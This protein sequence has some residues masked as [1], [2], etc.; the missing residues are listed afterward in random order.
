MKF[1][2][3]IG[4]IRIKEQ[5]SEALEKNRLSH[6]LLFSG[7]SG[8]GKRQMAWALA[9]NLLC[10]SEN[11]ACGT[12][13][14]CHQI[15][16]RMSESVFVVKFETLQIRI[17]DVKGIEKFISLQT[18]HKAKIVLID[19]A[20][21]LNIRSSNFLLKL[22]EEPP[23]KTYFFLISSQA[24]KLPLT[25]RSRMQNLHFEPLRE[26]ELRHLIPENYEEWMIPASRGQLDL[27]EMFSH[28]GEER[29][30]VILLLEEF[31][32]EKSLSL[33]SMDS[34]SKALT[35]SVFNQQILRDARLLK[36]GMRDKIIHK[37]KLGLIEK[38]SKLPT[39]KLDW[40]L[41]KSFSLERDLKSGYHHTLCLENFFLREESHV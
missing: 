1:P 19:E 21:K 40:I 34:R 16:K 29:E 2:E 3:V 17:D 33:D 36:S 23:P 8:V 32:R 31:L 15:S 25:I 24:S 38:L 9:K 5:L 10:E 30:Q 28:Q 11:P 13:S 37:D 22:I 14:Q 7:P 26:E 6:A 12:C 20:E 18:A 35:F 4:H 41:E 39:S 27:F